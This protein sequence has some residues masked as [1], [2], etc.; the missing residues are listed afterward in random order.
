MTTSAGLSWPAGGLTDINT[1]QIRRQP[2]LGGLINEYTN[3]A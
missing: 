1:Q 2:I 3:A